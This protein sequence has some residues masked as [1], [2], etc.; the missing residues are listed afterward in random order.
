MIKKIVFGFI[1]VIVFL[2]V[3][4]MALGTSNDK[5]YT[6]SNTAI[7]DVNQVKKLY[8]YSYLIE[9]YDYNIEVEYHKNKTGRH[10]LAFLIPALKKTTNIAEDSTQHYRYLK[11][12][13][14]ARYYVD[15]DSLD[16]TETETEVI[17]SNLQPQIDFAFV[18]PDSPDESVFFSDDDK[19]W[20]KK[21][22]DYGNMIAK[23]LR[24]KVFE[25][26]MTEQKQE[27]AMQK[28]K[29]KLTKLYAG[30]TDKQVI[31]N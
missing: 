27:K 19:F 25:Q 16:I 30:V 18:E 31:F 14:L 6:Y 10:I 21:Y 12:K 29:E 7:V 28:A 5:N 9:D 11:V 20:D 24:D 1:G 2:F 26:C 4:C 17:I 22:H 15:I 3:C 8:L 13:E 23:S